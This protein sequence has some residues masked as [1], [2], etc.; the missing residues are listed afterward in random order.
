[1]RIEENT[2]KSNALSTNFSK[3]GAVRKKEQHHKQSDTIQA[4]TLNLADDPI[5]KRK[6]Q[7]QAMAMSLL[8]N[9]FSSDQKIDDDLA[10]RQERISTLTKENDEYNE[11]LKDIKDQ[12]ESL[13]EF[14]GVTD[15]SKEQQDL[16][17][18][19]KERNSMTNPTVR[20]SDQEKQ[21]L[22]TIHINGT[23]DYQ[24]AS[25]E[26]DG[27]EK[28]LKSKLTENKKAIIEENAII[29]GVRQ[30]RL[31]SHDMVDAQKQ[32]DQIMTAAN[33]EIIG[34]LYEEVKDNQDKKL[35]EQQE[36]AEKKKKAAEELEKRI[37]AAK[38]DKE[39]NTNKNDK[40]DAMYKLGNSL[41]SVRKKGTSS[42][43]EDVKK[44]LSHIISELKLTAEDLKGA[45]VD[46][47]L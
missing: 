26:L 37:E 22:E 19:R 16:E 6:K 25:L 1:M 32:G 31:K 27:A 44:S 47:N 36:A 33:K 17:L 8:S 20:L 23:T 12:R 3:I 42:T 28:D 15:D 14:Y 45:V 21:Q 38:T 40:M 7:A 24:K 41:D 13:K 4:S 2:A 46:E 11:M 18:L 30:E 39:K 34:M 10:E 29:R 9:V 5:Q 35:E 43:F